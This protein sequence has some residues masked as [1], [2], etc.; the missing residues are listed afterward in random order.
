MTLSKIPDFKVAPQRLLPQ[1]SG[2]LLD[3]SAA[4]DL[5]TTYGV[6]S[7]RAW[8]FADGSEHLSLQASSKQ[9]LAADSKQPALV[10]VHSECATG[11][12]F[13]SLRCDCGPQ[14]Q[15]ALHRIQQ[16][17]G[18]LLYVR[19][20][21]GRGIGLLNKLRSYA[22]QDQGLD[23]VEANLALGLPADARNYQQ[24]GHIL[25]GLG[26]DQIRLLSNNPLKAEVLEKVGIKV[27]QLVS[28][29][30]PAQA[31]NRKY[32]QTKRDRMSHRLT[33]LED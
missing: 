24:V 32:L 6:F 16:E 18:F 11:D 1:V 14:L 27:R 3:S 15:Q 25:R 7:V 4:V 10:R 13:A 9:S 17:G 12:I 26:L 30:I 31:E 29:Q 22:L 33:S 20:Q 21:E 8:A 19:Q 5:P 2:Q 28:H 23:T